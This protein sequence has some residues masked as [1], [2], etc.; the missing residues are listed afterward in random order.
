MTKPNS[1]ANSQSRSGTVAEC[2]PRDPAIQRVLAATDYGRDNGDALE[3]GRTCAAALA[4]WLSE[5]DDRPGACAEKLAAV[6]RQMGRAPGS[7][8]FG[9]LEHFAHLAAVGSRRVDVAA[10]L[11]QRNV[12]DPFAGG[13]NIDWKL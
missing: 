8:R 7:A 3:V 2:M 11:A 4:Q 1:R 6:L 13:P 9:F 5:N 12:Y 10:D